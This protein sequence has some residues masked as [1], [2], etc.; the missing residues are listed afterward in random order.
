MREW[1]LTSEMVKYRDE[2]VDGR[3]MVFAS[4]G[5]STGKRMDW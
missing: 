4:L 1:M 3:G 5:S 2:E